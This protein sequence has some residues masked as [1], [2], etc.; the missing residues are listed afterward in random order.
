[1][2]RE[3][4]QVDVSKLARQDVYAALRRRSGVGAAGQTEPDQDP[5]QRLAELTEPLRLFA[6]GRP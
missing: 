6:P 2:R 1:M 4:A 5:K 3:P